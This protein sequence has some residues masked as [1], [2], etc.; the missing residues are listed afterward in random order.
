MPDEPQGAK[1]W[2]RQ[3]NKP[4]RARSCMR[5]RAAPSDHAAGNARKLSDGTVTHMA[6]MTWLADFV[7]F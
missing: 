5:C 7:F 4:M 6:A 2:H 3:W 1:L